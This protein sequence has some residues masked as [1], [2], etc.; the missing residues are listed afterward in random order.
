MKIK[1]GKRTGRITIQVHSY[2]TRTKLKDIIPLTR[3]KTIKM[4]EK[5]FEEL[6]SIKPQETETL[7]IIVDEKNNQKTLQKILECLAWE[8][9]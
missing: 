1:V 8:M 5:C 7:E 6:K 2:K 3:E 9:V 4:L